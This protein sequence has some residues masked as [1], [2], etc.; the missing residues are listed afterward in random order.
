MSQ[1]T[2]DFERSA[3]AGEDMTAKQFYIVQLDATGKIEVAEGA[4]DLVVGVLQNAPYTGEQATYRFAGTT[5][6]IS[7]GTIAIGAMVTTDGSGGKAVTTTTEGDVVIG[8][9]VGTAA[10]AAD[11]IIEVQMGVTSLAT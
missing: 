3:V 4:T 2:R 1:S 8:R 10:A 11:D 6:V 7:A 5:K 9:Y